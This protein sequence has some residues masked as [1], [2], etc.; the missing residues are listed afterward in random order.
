MKL[1]GLHGRA[2]SGKDTAKLGLKDYYPLAFATPLKEAAK[3]LY[4]LTDEQ[5]YGHLKEEVD[6]R[7]GKSPRQI[8]QELGDHCR[9]DNPRFFS[10]HM[11][12]RIENAEKQGIKKIVITDVRYDN[13]AKLIEELHGKVI[14]IK[15]NKT[16]TKLSAH[17]SEQ[18]I[19][20]RYIKHTVENNGTI[21]QLC[22]K[23]KVLECI[24]K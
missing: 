15:R 8:F 23:I 13:E 24:G 14:E 9:R 7:W 2:G 16:T 20:D 11:R 18:R 6:P 10:I 4:C 3:M 1:I 17:S 12:S 19:S 22:E 21:E 5:L